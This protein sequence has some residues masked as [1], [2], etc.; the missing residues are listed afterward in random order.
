MLPIQIFLTIF[1]VLAGIKVFSRMK[2][3][4]LPKP[5]AALWMLFWIF[6][7]LVVL[8]PDIT[9]TVARIFGVGRGAD[10]VIY[11]SLAI[12]FFLL[13]RIM[14]R[15]EKISREITKLVRK[16]TLEKK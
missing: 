12:I 10:I 4:E 14:V 6:A 2:K 13:F 9:F 15:Q 7:I 8:K 11:F 1:F 5:A 16:E 3:G